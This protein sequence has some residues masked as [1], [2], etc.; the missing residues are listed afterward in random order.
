MWENC[1]KDVAIADLTME[2]GLSGSVRARATTLA[3]GEISWH[4]RD[5]FAWSKTGRT[6]FARRG[7]TKDG[8]R[9]TK[10]PTEKNTNFA[11]P[12]GEYLAYAEPPCLRTHLRESCRAPELRVVQW[13]DRL[14]VADLFVCAVTRAEIAVGIGRLPDGTR[15]E[16]VATA[17][18]AMFGDAPVHGGDCSF[19]CRRR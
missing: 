7:C 16:K 13:P 18:K 17:A 1:D 8:A 3:M 12:L 4:S 14:P 9:Q 15:K 19:G 11:L 5:H 2:N 6:Q 10:R